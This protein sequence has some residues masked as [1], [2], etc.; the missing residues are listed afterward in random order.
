MNY[1]RPRLYLQ[2]M[3]QGRRCIYGC[4]NC[5]HSSHWASGA[6]QALPF[7]DGDGRG[8]HGVE[9]IGLREQMPRLPTLNEVPVAA[10]N[11]R[12][13]VIA[14]GTRSGWL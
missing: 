5:R 14:G 11:E 12:G 13:E 9:A 4:E 3:G 10:V 6:G 2:S 8:G 1:R 7:Y